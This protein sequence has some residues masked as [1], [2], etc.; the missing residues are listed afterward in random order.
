LIVVR[1]NNSTSA[2]QRSTID[3][4]S[5]M[6]DSHC[7]LTDE[8]LGSQLEPVLSRA[9]AAGVHRVI[10]ISTSVADAEDC[11][12]L[13][14]G[15]DDVRCTVG[16]HP[17]YVG[18]E[19]FARVPQLRGLQASPSVVA[20]GEIGL[21]YHYGRELRDRQFQFFEAQLQIAADFNR[22]VVIHCREAVDDALAV[23]AKFP[24]VRCDFHCFTGTPDEARRILD[25]GYFLGFTGP[26]TY[27]RSDE[28]REVV[29][30]TPLDRLLVETDAPYLAPEPMRKFKVNEPAW[31]MHVAAAVAALKGVS[32]EEVDWAT[33]ANVE[34]FFGWVKAP[35]P[36]GHR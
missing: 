9:K 22:A 10:T 16:V 18:E 8:R 32:L 28:L 13:C 27:K 3:K 25:A 6:I 24:G 33:S 1:R 31:V 21:D 34:R 35:A 36:P 4:Q 30:L 2:Q 15:R 17:N 7:H 29:K 20:I 23:L 5:G 26:I 14:A 11:V 12:T 19:D